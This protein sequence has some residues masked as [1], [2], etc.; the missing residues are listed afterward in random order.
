MIQIGEAPA[1]FCQQPWAVAAFALVPFGLVIPHQEGPAA[2]SKHWPFPLHGHIHWDLAMFG[3]WDVHCLHSPSH[4]LTNSFGWLTDQ[5]PP[6]WIYLILLPYGILLIFNISSWTKGQHALK[7]PQLVNW[8]A[9]WSRAKLSPTLSDKIIL[10][11]CRCSHFKPH[12]GDDPPPR[13]AGLPWL[14]NESMT[15]PTAK[16]MWGFTTLLETRFSPCTSPRLQPP[17]LRNRLMVQKL[18]RARHG[19]VS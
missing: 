15:L 13:P 9:Y 8:T 3:H 6:L 4:T 1:S 5:M 12:D 16:F 18:P 19:K 7:Y 14:V 17:K 11:L 10:F 2:V